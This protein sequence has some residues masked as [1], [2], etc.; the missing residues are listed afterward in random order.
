[1]NHARSLTA[2]RE[3]LKTLAAGAASLA[4]PALAAYPDKPIRI[5]VTFPAAAPAT[6]SRECSAN[7]SR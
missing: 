4:L 5:G 2:R 6:S 7:S 1:M 3:V